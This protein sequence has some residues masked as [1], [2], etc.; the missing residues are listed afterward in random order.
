M[1]FPG[2][3]GAGTG[4]QGR[5]TVKDSLSEPRHDLKSLTTS[6]IIDCISVVPQFFPVWE[7]PK[8]MDPWDLL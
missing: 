7:H 5:Y 6:I 8:N 1:P 3:G 4:F 2:H